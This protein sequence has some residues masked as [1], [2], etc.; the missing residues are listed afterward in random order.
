MNFDAGH[1]ACSDTRRV[2]SLTVHYMHYAREPFYRC[3]RR[4]IDY[5]PFPRIIFRVNRKR[6]MQYS[7]FRIATNN[8]WNANHLDRWFEWSALFPAVKMLFNHFI[9]IFSNES[10]VGKSDLKA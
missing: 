10:K 1:H 8:R 2:I 3:C 6:R 9:I 5:I 7:S 4:Y